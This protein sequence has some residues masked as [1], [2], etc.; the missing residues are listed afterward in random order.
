L[1]LFGGAN[2]VGARVH[3]CVISQGMKY[4]GCSIHFVTNSVDQ[5][6]VIIKKRVD[7]LPG[8]TPKTLELRVLEQEHLAYPEAMQLIV[9]GRVI[10]SEKENRCFVDRFSDNWD[11]EWSKRQQAYGELVSN[12][13]KNPCLKA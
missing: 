3:E 1:R 9:D 5:G 2:M 4:S 8:D 12:Q 11:I 7:V 13:K 6:P 10:V